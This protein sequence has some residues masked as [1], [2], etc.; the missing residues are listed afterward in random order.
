MRR[1]LGSVSETQSHAEQALAFK[2]LTVCEMEAATKTKKINEADEY[3]D[4]CQQRTFLFPSVS[5]KGRHQARHT[6][7]AH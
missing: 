4:T 6:G 1:A 3:H 2:A 7:L 5:H